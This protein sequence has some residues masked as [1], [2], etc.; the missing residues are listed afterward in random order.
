MEGPAWDN[1][2]ANADKTLAI[3]NLSD[4]EDPTNVLVLAKALVYTRTGISHYAEE[5][6]WAIRQVMGTEQ[7]GRTLALGRELPAYIIAA[8]LVTLPG[9]LDAEFRNWLRA[10]R[11]E[12]LQGRTLISTHEDRPNNWGTHA[13][14]A[15]I[16][17]ALY[18]ED[19]EDLDRAAQVFH[20]WLGDRS[21]YAGF[22]YGR[23]LSWQANPDTPVGINPV[24]AMKDGHSIDGALPEEMRR[25]GTFTWPAP[26]ENYA[27]EALQGA[28]A[29]AHMLNRAGYDAWLWEDQ[30]LFRA[31]RWLNNEADYAASGDDTWETYLINYYYE[32][33]FPVVNPA[34]A[35]KNV[36]WLDWTHQ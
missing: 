36:G 31:Y 7:G 8:D 32:T 27:Y 14:A 15:R 18:L 10:V 5:V 28:L 12:N 2:K 34:R 13:G 19:W 6:T 16:A 22:K 17:I 30:A 4:Q 26:H 33:N 21:S 35:G 25:S 1:L 29:Q 20:G 11:T 23:D 3:P 9:D 24:G